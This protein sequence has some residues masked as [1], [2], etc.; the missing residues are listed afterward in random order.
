MYCRKKFS[1]SCFIRII[2]QLCL[3]SIILLAGTTAYAA[4]KQIKI[5]QFSLNRSVAYLGEEISADITVNAQ[6]P[7]RKKV[8]RLRYYLDK[9]EIGR[10]TISAFD[11]AGN[12]N[13]IF[14]FKDSPEGR[15]QFRVV[16][17]IE[18]EK[19][20][21]DEVSRQLAILSLPT[22]MTEQISSSG[23]DEK[24][25]SDDPVSDKPDLSVE[26]INFDIASPRVGE[27]I[28]IN[29]KI[30]NT[31]TV[32]ADNVK[33][34]I[35]INGLP[36]GKDISMNIAAGSQVN[37]DTEFKAA[38][39]G[40]KDV[41]IFIN[42]DGKVDEKS[43]RNNLLSKILIVRPAGKN[44][45]PR[46]I[47]T[48]PKDKAKLDRLANLVIYIETISGAH[49]TSDGNVQFYITNNSQSA[50]TKA[51]VMGVQ[52]LQESPGQLWLIRKPVKS[53]Q[54]GETVTLAVKW[55]E[56]Q[57]A[58]TKLFVAAADIEGKIDETDVRD[59]HTRPFRVVSTSQKLTIPEPVRIKAGSKP[60]IIITS[61]LP[62]GRL[63]SNEKLIVNWQTSGDIGSLVHITIHNSQSKEV[64]L[65]STS[66]NDGAYSADLS[67]LPDGKYVLSISSK[68]RAVSPQKRKFQIARQKT[69]IIPKLVSPTNGA[70]FRGEQQMKI[71]WP[72][73]IKTVAGQKLDL[74]LLESSSEKI[75][76]LNNN[77]VESSKGQF[78]WQVPDDGSVFGIYK[79]QARS[80]DGRVLAVTDEIELLPNF[81]SFEQLSTRANK[82]EIQTDLEIARTSFKG[83][84]LEYLIMNN[85]PAD[86]ST[87]GLYGYNF[88]TYFVRKVPI[89]KEDDLIICRS[90]LLSELPQGEGQ[91]ISLGRDPDCPLGERD[92]SAKFEYVINRFTL[93][94]LENQYLI[95]PKPFNNM[96][97]FYWPE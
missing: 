89:T 36:Y 83:Q 65:S 81:V 35:F 86:I 5:E 95:D 25:I 67:A 92:F 55:P 45:K 66:N 9:K 34:R 44:K 93:P 27:K 88:T 14:K 63:H 17:D 85:G 23:P 31:G 47:A 39:Q 57:L 75:V 80:V 33:I 15:Y 56:D 40:K 50:A 84:N 13:T 60:E 20:K 29:S 6:A 64:V 46:A 26:E 73:S 30:A 1:T 38:R 94:I 49:Y 19:L 32:P 7:F 91:V 48:T 78:V 22:G 58:S 87:S 76:K 61:P 12:A 97:K 11:S 53:L 62:D 68:N 70:S 21:S 3:L 74:V 82:K 72:V 37:I 42:P 90:T 79:L 18:N 8:L 4:K 77:P 69:A 24:T 43:N 96:S 52:Q 59:N 10:Q 54:P 51:F 41:L 71:I 28:L 2:G 16:L